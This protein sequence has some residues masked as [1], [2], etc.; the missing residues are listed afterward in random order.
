MNTHKQGRASLYDNGFKIVIAR[1]YLTGNLGYG[2]LAKKYGLS[3]DTVRGFVRWYKR[4][5]TQDLPLVTK[6]EQPVVSSDPDK[7]QILKQLKDANLKVTG[8]EMLI[9]TAQ[10]EL[11]IDIVKKPGTKQ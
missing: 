6:I 1:E 11:G 10:K 9:E 4:N 5:Y 7:E 8:L 2:M 3:L